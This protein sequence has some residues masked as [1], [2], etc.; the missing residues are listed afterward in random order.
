M[1]VQQTRLKNLIFPAPNPEELGMS[2]LTMGELRAIGRV[3]EYHTEGNVVYAG[4][5]RPCQ[6]CKKV[7]LMCSH[8]LE[9]HKR[10]CKGSDVGWMKSKFKQDEEWRLSSSDP[11]LALAVRQQGPISMGS[12]GSIW[13]SPDGKYLK[14]RLGG[15]TNRD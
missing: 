6:I 15:D 4:S 9:S 2:E 13:L 1:S 12:G 5:G 8:D 10:V 3:T 14:R 11:Q 7:W